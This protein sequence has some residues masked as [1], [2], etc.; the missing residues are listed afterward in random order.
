ML[1]KYQSCY[2]NGDSAEVTSGFLPVTSTPHLNG[3]PREGE[4]RQPSVLW[5]ERGRDK[6]G[7][8][9]RGVWRDRWKLAARF[10]V[11]NSLS[12]HTLS[13]IPAA[14]IFYVMFLKDLFTLTSCFRCFL[15]S[16]ASLLHR[17]S[18]KETIHC[19]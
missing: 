12:D 10:R 17:L 13:G 4:N 5:L 8:I 15:T 18:C 16:E 1:C 11:P 6:G 19:V 7:K 14:K 2:F 9:E 3:P